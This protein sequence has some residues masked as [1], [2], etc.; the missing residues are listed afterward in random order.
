MRFS[1]RRTQTISYT[2]RTLMGFLLLLF[3]LK[4]LQEGFLELSCI[5]DIFLGDATGRER[6]KDE[7]PAILKKYN[8][9]EYPLTSSVLGLVFGHS[10]GDNRI[11][12]LLA[13]PKIIK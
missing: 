2:H 4:G 11:I 10:M 3:F 12:Y 8:I 5:K 13:P 6:V 7:C 1:Y 9:N